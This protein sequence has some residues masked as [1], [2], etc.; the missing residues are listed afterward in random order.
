MQEN[1]IWNPEGKQAQLWVPFDEYVYRKIIDVCTDF[2]KNYSKLNEKHDNTDNLANQIEIV[3]E[4]AINCEDLP[5]DLRHPDLSVGRVTYTSLHKR[6][7][8]KY[9]M[10]V[11]NELRRQQEKKGRDPHGLE[12]LLENNGGENDR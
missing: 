11:M 9:V 1:E 8:L 10:Q 7:A 5:E 2:I 12:K 3:R 6:I 4:F